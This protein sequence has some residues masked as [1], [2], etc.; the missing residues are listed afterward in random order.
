MDM[1]PARVQGLLSLLGPQV[2]LAA[3][4]SGSLEPAR[5]SSGALATLIPG[6]GVL[7]PPAG[8]TTAMK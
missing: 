2:C 8:S 5:P 1:P 3:L 7:P 6:L 4:N